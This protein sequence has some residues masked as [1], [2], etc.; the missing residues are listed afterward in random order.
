MKTTRVPASVC[1]VCGKAN[2]AASN[3]QD[4][5]KPNDVSI[6]WYCGHLMIFADDLKL[7]QPTVAEVAELS[8]HP[9]VMQMQRS[10]RQ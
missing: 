10:R 1:P 4:R 2:N 3:G 5:P 6:C 8:R 9:T 7:R